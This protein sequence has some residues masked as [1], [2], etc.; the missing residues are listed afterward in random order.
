MET[1]IEQ[2]IPSDIRL[3]KPLV[4]DAPLSEHQLLAH[5]K[6]LALKNKT[7]RSLIGMGYYGT[8][9][10]PVILR[11]I[12]ENPGWYTSYTLISRNFPGSLQALFNS[13]MI[14]ILPALLGQQLHCLMKHRSR[15]AMRICTS[16]APDF[17]NRGPQ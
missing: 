3:K 16:C 1:L 9:P 12:F 2:P 8:A 7:F 13:L 15:E 17:C 4:L 10:L 5:M 6:K 11:N 14:C